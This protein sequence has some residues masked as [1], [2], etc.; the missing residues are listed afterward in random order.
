MNIKE[1]KFYAWSNLSYVMV[2]KRNSQI[3]K[4]SRSITFMNF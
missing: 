1:K 3:H 4:N 2:R